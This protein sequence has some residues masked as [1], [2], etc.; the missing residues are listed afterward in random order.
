M[1]RRTPQKAVTAA[2]EPSPADTRPRLSTAALAALIGVSSPRI[3][4]L[5]SAGVITADGDG[6][7]DAVRTLTALLGFYRQDNATRNARAK[8]IRA[9]AA[10]A[11]MRTRRSLRQLL[12]TTEVRELFDVVAEAL[13]EVAQRESTRVYHDL[14]PVHGEEI[15][16][17]VAT[18]TRD[19]MTGVANGMTAGTVE[20][21]RQ[22]HAEV[23]PDPT[24]ISA[25]YE[26]L[27]ANH[28]AGTDDAE[29]L[30]D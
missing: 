18:R 22:L 7:F 21:L 5:R 28:G 13:H 1:P 9:N 17:K 16:T 4:Q 29:T 24:R 26:R 12:D 10:A 30:D 14:L 2:P 6:D 3:S 8:A 15:A 19:T 20:L 27:V 11:E 25:L 23:M